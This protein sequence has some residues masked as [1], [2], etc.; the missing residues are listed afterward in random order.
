MASLPNDAPLT[1]APIFVSSIATKQG[2]DMI[3]VHALGNS[4]IEIG[5]LRIAPASVRMFALLLY[6]TAER[7]RRLSRSALQALVFPDQTEK[8]GSHSLRQLIYKLRQAGAELEATADELWLSDQATTT[9]YEAWVAAERL[10]LAQLSAIQ[11]GF[12]PNFRPDR[13]EAFAQWL[14]AFRSRITLEL[15]RVVLRD[16]S[17]TRSVGDWRTTERAAH[18]NHR[19]ILRV[20]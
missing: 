13:L 12:L 17:Y 11:G 1:R 15:R 3:R 20:R 16:L 5:N 10:T 9:D 8:N 18:A 6:V 7:R 14:E 4:V 2:I 19:Q